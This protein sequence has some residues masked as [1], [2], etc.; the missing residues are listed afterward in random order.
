MFIGTV[1]QLLDGSQDELARLRGDLAWAVVDHVRDQAPRD[2]RPLG[3][4]VLGDDFVSVHKVFFLV[5]DLANDIRFIANSLIR[6]RDDLQGQRCPGQSCHLPMNDHTAGLVAGFHIEGCLPA[7]EREWIFSDQLR[8]SFQG[9]SYHAGGIGE[10]I[11]KL[12][13]DA[14]D[15]AGHIRA[16]RLELVCIGGKFQSLRHPVAGDPMFGSRLPIQVAD[17][18]EIV[19]V[20]LTPAGVAIQSLDGKWRMGQVGVGLPVG[21]ESPH[22]EV[23]DQS[24]RPAHN[25]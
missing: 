4:I 3:D 16:I 19:E 17:Q 9:E 10:W 5:E 1:A 25:C 22:V 2:S 7:D 8:I 21:L 15:Q 20:P 14:E 23:A 24:P 11:A 13:G 18:V 12:V 6:Y